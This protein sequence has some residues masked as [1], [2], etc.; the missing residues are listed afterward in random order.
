[1]SALSARCAAT[2][3]KGVDT[4]LVTDL[5]QAA[6][7]NLFD[8]AILISND[9]DFVPA[10]ELIQNRTTTRVIHAG[11]RSGR[12]LQNACWSHVVLDEQI[13]EQ[14]IDRQRSAG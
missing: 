2:V 4:A 14:L 6:M 3:E 10:V 5:I 13:L 7:D 8:D 9:A 1:M 11:I 12:Q